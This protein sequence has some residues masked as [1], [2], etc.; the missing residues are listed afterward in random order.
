LSALL[1]APTLYL[2]TATARGLEI[3][4]LVLLLANTAV[5]DIVRS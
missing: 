4:C 1:G 5:S 3:G 2:A